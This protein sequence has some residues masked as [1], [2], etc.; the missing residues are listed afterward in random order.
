M[1]LSRRI[2]KEIEILKANSIEGIHFMAQLNSLTF[3]VNLDPP[4]KSVYYGFS[5]K[6]VIVL[7]DE[8]PMQPPKIKFLSKVFHPNIGENGKI[9][10]DILGRCWSPVINLRC[11]LANIRLILECPYSEN[12]ENTLADELWVKDRQRAY[13]IARDW[14]LIC[15][16]NSIIFE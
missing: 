14:C 7:P 6:L 8:Y 9:G 5:F 1:I 15:V 13:N 12:I 10:I 11:V 4:N 2:I 16:E 3:I